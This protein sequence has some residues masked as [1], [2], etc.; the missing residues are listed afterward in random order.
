MELDEVRRYWDSRAAGD[1][2]AQSTTQDYYLRE[3]EFRAVAGQIEVIRPGRVVDIGC[4]DARTTLR[5]AQR[6]PT[7]SFMGM[8]YSDVMIGNAKRLLSEAGTKNVEVRLADVL[9]PL[10]IGQVDLAYTTRCLINLPGWDLQQRAIANIAH[11]LRQR[12]HFV[13]IENFVEGHDSFNRIREA[14]GLPPIPV[15]EHNLF[16]ERQKLIDY[17]DRMFELIEEVNISSTYY[18]VS[19]IIYSRLCADRGEVPDYFDKHH[20]YA[21]SLPFAGEFGPVRLVALRR[22]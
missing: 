12:G 18:L 20:E 13:M 10:A 19:R 21:A 8:D 2:T 9:R 6:F 4:G 17:V 16:F 15:R 1:A 3:I 14:F 11:A 22:T 5:L 7:I